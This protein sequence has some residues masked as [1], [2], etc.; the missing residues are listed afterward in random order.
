MLGQLGLISLGNESNRQEEES[1][2]ELEEL[3]PQNSI[4]SFPTTISY[5]SSNPWDWQVT[6]NTNSVVNIA[7]FVKSS[8]IG[9][10]GNLYVFGSTYASSNNIHQ[11]KFG[12]QTISPSGH[13]KNG[14]FAVRFNMSSSTWDWQVTENTNSVVNIVDFVKSSQIGPDG[15]LYVFGSTYASSNNIHQL[16]FGSQNISPSGHSKN[17]YFAVRF[18]MSSST[19]D[20]QVTENTNSVVNIVD[21]VKSS[22]IG[23]DGNLYVFG[24]TYASSNNIH[25]LKFG[26]QNISPS[27][28]SKNGYFAVRFDMSSSTWDW[29]VTENTNSV[30][31]IVDFVKSSQIGPDGNLYVFGST[32]ASSNNIHQL[33]F[34]SQNYLVLAG[35]GKDGY[36]AVRYDMKFIH[37]GLGLA[38]VTANTHWRRRYC[39]SYV[40]GFANWTGR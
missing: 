23:P 32:Y 4:S 9:P 39:M 5:N 35:Q 20:W 30:V 22:Q 1:S 12:S 11:L 27:G 40:T 7:D 6:E 10:D 18:D 3:I 33:K 16:K 37:F 13:S 17:G 29:Q 38:V 31:N 15:N 25:Q 2:K 34:G 8:Q 28:H 14:Y 24:S 21:F 26:S 36:F 19:W